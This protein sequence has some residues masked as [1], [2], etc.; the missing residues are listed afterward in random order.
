MGQKILVQK[1]FGSKKSKH[2]LGNKNLRRFFLDS[3]YIL[4]TKTKKEIG[5]KRL[6][7]KMFDSKRNFNPKISKVQNNLIDKILCKK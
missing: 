1:N 5:V 3:T 4:G 7:T 2:F 6:G